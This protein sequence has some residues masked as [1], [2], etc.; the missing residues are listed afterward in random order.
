MGIR[1]KYQ[2][3]EYCHHFLRD[4]IREGDIW[5]PPQETAVTQSSYADWQGRTER[6]M[7]LMFRSRRC[8]AQRNGWSARG[9][10]TGQ[11]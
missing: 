7:P 2:I 4:Y 8:A 11:S 3:T 10:V 6:S 9:C 1:E 5:M